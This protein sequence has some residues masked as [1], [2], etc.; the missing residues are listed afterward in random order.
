MRLFKKK[1]ILAYLIMPIP[2]NNYPRRSRNKRNNRKSIKRNTGARSQSKQILRLDRQIKQLRKDTITHAQWTMPL[3]GQ[4]SNSIDLADGLFTVSS[5]IRP[6]A[7]QPLFQT[8]IA[9]GIPTAPGISFTSQR[10]RVNSMSF[11]VVFSPTDSLLP[12]TPWLINFYILKFKSET[13]SDVLQKTNG[14]NTAGLNTAAA[15]N[16][17]IVLRDDLAGGLS[18]MIRWNPAAFD[19]CYQKTLKIANIVNET[20]VPDEDI[21]ITNTHDALRRIHFRIKMGNTLQPA[22][23]TWKQMNELDVYPNDRYYMVAHVGGFTGGAANA[24]SVTM[25]TLQVVNT[26]MY[27]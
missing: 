14:F 11:S 15:A 6:A 27:E 1:K 20:I 3:E 22:T 17:N 21:A 12:L 25:S 19:I 7:W 9:G 26:T 5:L 23:G 2:T 13:A 8:T 16:S 24:N 4:D 10:V 18:T